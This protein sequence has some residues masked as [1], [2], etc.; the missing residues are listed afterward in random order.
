MG[1]RAIVVTEPSPGGDW[2]HD[3]YGQF[4]VYCAPDGGFTMANDFR[5]GAFDD[6]LKDLREDEYKRD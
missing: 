4:H 3:H 6:R 2:L 1:D 5:C